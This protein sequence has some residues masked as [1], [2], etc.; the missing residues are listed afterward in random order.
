MLSNDLNVLNILNVLNVSNVEWSYTSLMFLF[1]TSQCTFSLAFIQS[2]FS[3]PFGQRTFILP[4]PK[5]FQ[6]G[7]TQIQSKPNPWKILQ[8]FGNF[9][10]F[11]DFSHFSY[12]QFFQNFERWPM[13]TSPPQ[14][15][16]K[17]V[18]WAEIIV[19]IQ[20]SKLF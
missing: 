13:A 7:T 5:Y 17:P 19:Q 2:P 4:L 12:F 15:R 16:M 3:L 6:L 18:Q 8:F 14:E 20:C 9:K 10:F 11:E 1:H